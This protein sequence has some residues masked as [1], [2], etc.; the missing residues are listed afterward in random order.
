MN[1]F[2][3][4]RKRKLLFLMIIPAI[5]YFLIFCY[6]PMFGIILAFKDYNY[7]QGVMGSPW[8]GWSNFAFLYKSGTLWRVTRNTV[9]YNAAFIVLDL[10]TQ[11]GIAILLNEI[12]SKICK[13][14]TQS[15]M[16]LPYFVSTVLLGAFVYNMFSYE[17]G[18]LNNIL[19]SFGFEKFD[20]SG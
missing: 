12:G 3:E 18:A 6:V 15:M 2:V 11:V 13:K 8:V 9:L 19:T 17:R 16:F 10:V 7:A 4:V 14:L 1:V 20:V 5:I